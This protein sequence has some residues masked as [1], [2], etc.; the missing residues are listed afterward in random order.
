MF[1]SPVFV[2]GS[3]CA[4]PALRRASK[5]VNDNVAQDM[6]YRQETQGKS[7]NKS[8]GQSAGMPFYA[9]FR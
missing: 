7:I 2:S 9:Y 5:A 6:Q 1:L 3:S 8:Q 4:T